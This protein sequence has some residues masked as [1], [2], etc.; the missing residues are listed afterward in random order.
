MFEG[1][2]NKLGQVFDN[3][4]GRG[5]LSEADVDAALR[6]VRL[7]VITVRVFKRDE[8]VFLSV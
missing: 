8:H 1:L 4:R 2:S 7:A 6:D 5:A 3:I